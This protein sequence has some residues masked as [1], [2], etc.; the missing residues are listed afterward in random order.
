M[1]VLSLFYAGNIFKFE[2]ANHC[3]QFLRIE[4]S[5][6]PDTETTSMDVCVEILLE[7]NQAIAQG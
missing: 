5:K 1:D 6:M 3:G 7:C 4:R 2:S